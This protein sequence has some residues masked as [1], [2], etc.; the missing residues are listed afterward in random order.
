MASMLAKAIREDEVV[1]PTAGPGVQRYTKAT[2]APS[3]A[4]S[5]SSS[6][7]SDSGSSSSPDTSSCSRSAATRRRAGPLP[8]RP[9]LVPMIFPPGLRPPAPVSADRHDIATPRQAFTTR[10]PLDFAKVVN[11]PLFDLEQV[12]HLLKED[13]AHTVEMMMTIDTLRSRSA[14]KN[15]INQMIPRRL[16]IYQD[17][18]CFVLRPPKPRPRKADTPHQHEDM[19]DQMVA[20]ATK[21]LAQKVAVVLTPGPGKASAKAKARTR[22]QKGPRPPAC[23]L[24]FRAWATSPPAPRASPRSPGM[25]PHRSKNCAPRPPPS[26]LG[27]RTAGDDHDIRRSRGETKHRAA[28]AQVERTTGIARGH[29]HRGNP[30]AQGSPTVDSASGPVQLRRSE[31]PTQRREPYR[32]AHSGIGSD[33]SDSRPSAQGATSEPELLLCLWRNASS[34]QP[35]GLFPISA[36]SCRRYGRPFLYCQVDA[37][38]G[39]GGNGLR[40]AL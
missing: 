37:H 28:H 23:P 5:I 6:S 7:D 3:R 10:Y 24:P 8:C 4:P 39:G 27:A 17:G 16:Q 11:H 29:P 33:A 21:T 15:V 20:P 30:H 25:P 14:M 38:V 34:K 36:D 19:F 26:A 12:E 9:Q 1:G 2:Q 31:I 32:R 22:G 18:N 35:S 40:V 13:Q